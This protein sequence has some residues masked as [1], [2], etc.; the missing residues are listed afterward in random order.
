MPL[1][2]TKNS[3]VIG[4]WEIVE[5]WQ[6]LLG[7]FQNKTKYDNDVRQIQS[8][9]RKCEWLA[10]RLLVEKLSGAE[11]SVCYRE[12]GAPFLENSPFN[13]SISHTKGFAAIILAQSD[14]PGIDIE[15]RSGR[16]MKLTSKYLSEEELNLFDSLPCN[17]TADYDAHAPQSTLA[18][19]CWCAKETVYKALQVTDVDFIK[20]LHIAPFTLSEEG[21]ISLK[22]TKTTSQ[23]TY[24]I[25][26]Q[27]T[28]GYI[29]TWKE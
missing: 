19:I 24:P 9:K 6:D 1:K 15:Y 7:L 11:T 28:N 12:N 27:V 13:I 29:L 8:D 16:A 25:H 4:V 5:P 14:H 22:E 18:T 23:N 20:H 21:I 3:P 26:Y 10:V 2:Y 17:Y